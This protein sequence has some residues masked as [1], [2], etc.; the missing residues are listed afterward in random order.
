MRQEARPF[1]DK[2]SRQK[3]GG[4]GQSAKNTGCERAKIQYLCERIDKSSWSTV[5]YKE[6][7]NACARGSETF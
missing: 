7:E 6:M 1:L 2:K 5:Y 4:Q 3:K